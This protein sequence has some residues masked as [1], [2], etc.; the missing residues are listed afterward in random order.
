M[1]YLVIVHQRSMYQILHSLV[2]CHVQY[3]AIMMHQEGWLVVYAS[4]AV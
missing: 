2:L 3:I 1:L 4:Q